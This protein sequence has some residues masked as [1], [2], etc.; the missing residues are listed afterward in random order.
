M[1]INAMYLPKERRALITGFVCTKHID[2]LVIAVVDPEM[3]D[4]IVETEIRD[5]QRASLSFNNPLNNT[6]FLKCLQHAKEAISDKEW[7]AMR[8][9]AVQRFKLG[10]IIPDSKFFKD[11]L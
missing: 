5:I 10:T 1:I 11:T 6:R 2:S 7:D 4:K 8:K 3:N 9:E